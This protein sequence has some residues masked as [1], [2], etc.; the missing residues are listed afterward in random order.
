MSTSNGNQETLQLFLRLVKEYGLEA[1]PI[2][3]QTEQARSVC[4]LPYE[5]RNPDNPTNII[6]DGSLEQRYM[7]VRGNGEYRRH[8][9]GAEM[10]KLRCISSESGIR[11]IE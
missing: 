6:A 8:P 11:L 7:T 2:E 4:K 5:I 9:T 1:S 10:D 3:F